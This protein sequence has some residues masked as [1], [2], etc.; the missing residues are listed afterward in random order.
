MSRNAKTTLAGLLP[1][2]KPAGP[3]SHDVIVHIRR[4]LTTHYKLLTRVGHAG[5]L[6]PFA[7]GLLLVAVGGATRLVEYTRPWDKTY[8]ATITLGAMSDTDDLTGAIT[9]GSP[10]RPTPH[11]IEAAVK[12]F[13]GTIRQVPP[14][15]SAV[16][17]KGK[18][19]YELSRAGLPAEALAK[20]GERARSV[21]IHRLDIIDYHYPELQ[22]RLTCSTGTYV[23]A[24]ARDMGQ[25][26]GTGAYV[27]ELRRTKIGTID[28]ARAVPLK[29][30][31]GQ[32][33]RS[34]L[35][36]T[37][38][39]VAHLPRITLTPANVAQ[40]QKG[41]PVGYSL[42]WPPLPPG[43]PIALFSTDRKLFGIGRYDPA[44]RT[45]SPTKIL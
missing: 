4:L 12:K 35:L 34:R 14:V 44:S 6:D 10:R 3:T 11:Q 9:P 41:Q 15:Y 8:E 39:L 36:P 24:L 27:H 32:N 13:T 29:K 18:K 16:K 40:C 43:Q 2:D 21:T 45:L 7:T 37:E 17:Y 22:I 33:L 28:I 5:T 1:I 19:L 38:T 26:L 31:T 25:E 30:L 20:A 23:R 42:S